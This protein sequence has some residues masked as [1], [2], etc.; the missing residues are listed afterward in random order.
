MCT[1]DLWRLCRYLLVYIVDV[2]Y[3]RPLFMHMRLA[4]KSGTF[5]HF[6]LQ[7]FHKVTNALQCW[8]SSFDVIGRILFYGVKKEK[9][10]SWLNDIATPT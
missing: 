2:M 9:L 1:I 3:K 8:L 10:Y 7:Q 5:I 6:Q 4:G